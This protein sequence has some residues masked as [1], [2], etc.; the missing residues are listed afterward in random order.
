MNKIKNLILKF[1][2]KLGSLT[3]FILG[4]DELEDEDEDEEEPEERIEFVEIDSPQEIPHEEKMIEKEEEKHEGLRKALRTGF[5]DNLKPL[6]SLDLSKIDDFDEMLAAMS[7]TSFGG[8]L[9]G[10]AADVMQAMYTDE[11]CFKVMTLSGAMT[12]GKMSLLICEMIDRGYVDA[13]IST[14]ALMAHGLVESLDM[15]HFKYSQEFDD[16]ELYYKGYDRIYDTLE[17]EKNLDDTA[18]I[19]KT[20][21]EDIPTT[22]MLSSRMITCEIGKYLAENYE[23]KGILR[24]AYMKK[25]PIFIP[26]FTDSELGLDI[27]TFNRERIENGQDPYKFDPYLDLESYTQMIE[28]HETLGIFTIGGGVPRN[29]AQQVGPYLD[30]V[31]KRTG[32]E[33]VFRRFKYGV[34]IC[35]ERVE[36]GGLSGCT[37]SEGVSWGKFVPKSEGGMFA[38]IPVDATVVWPLL[39]K[40]VIQ[41]IQK[42]K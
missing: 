26:A 11:N 25:V 1:V 32:G 39:L 8:R 14:G 23:G 2:I 16:T 42:N 17:L 4:L 18:E 27:G 5:E 34:R 6:E 40:G 20:I 36:W 30:I 35:P 37:Y 21:F 22:H 24:Q 15:P 31:G 33:D 12:A 38:E 10:E 9:V 41:R 7:K 13:I 19:V 29:W 28:D 3:L